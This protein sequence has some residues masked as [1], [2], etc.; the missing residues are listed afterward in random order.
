MNYLKTPRYKNQAYLDWV[1]SLPCAESGH[2]PAGDAHHLI[3]VGGMSGTGLTAPD[4]ASMPLTRGY[5]TRMHNE[6]ELWPGQW[7]MIA[8][9]LGRAIE[10]GKLRW[11]K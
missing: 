6:P 11:V 1:K 9:T 3:G 8:R 2:E 5:H 7:E 4:W 10:E